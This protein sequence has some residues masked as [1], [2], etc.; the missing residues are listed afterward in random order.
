MLCTAFVDC[1]FKCSCSCGYAMKFAS[2]VGASTQGKIQ[3]GYDP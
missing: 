3:A 2:G 1:S